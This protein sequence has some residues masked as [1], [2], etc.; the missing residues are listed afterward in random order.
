MEYTL[1]IEA[2]WNDADYI[3][4]VITVDEKT[5]NLVKKVCKV[6]GKEKR[7]NWPLHERSEILPKEKY[8]DFLTED[9][10]DEFEELVPHGD[11][12]IHSIVEIK[13]APKVNWKKVL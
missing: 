4:E 11:P 10:I 3:T 12:G 2:D 9:E 5:L 13:Y 8:K 7:H 6:I 1:F